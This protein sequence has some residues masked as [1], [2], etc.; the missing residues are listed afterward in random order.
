[1]ESLLAPRADDRATRDACCRDP[2]QAHLDPRTLVRSVSK[3]VTGPVSA[4][5]TS[6]AVKSRRSV[7]VRGARAMQAVGH[8][9]SSQF[10]YAVPFALA[11]LGQS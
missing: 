3:R 5:V 4:C 9:Q 7:R 11:P 1:M 6:S 10:P 2:V 8:V